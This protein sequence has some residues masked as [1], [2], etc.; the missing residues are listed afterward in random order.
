MISYES[1]RM[2]TLI[3][4]VPRL[5]CLLNT[6]NDAV[7]PGKGGQKKALNQNWDGIN[8]KLNNLF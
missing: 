6:L 1:S 8:L 4:P 5:G 7:I 3:G 2:Q